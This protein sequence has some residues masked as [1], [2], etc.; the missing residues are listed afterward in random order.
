MKVEVSIH[1]MRAA[2]RSVPAMQSA[3]AAVLVPGS[4]ELVLPTDNSMLQF[5]DAARDIHMDKLQV[6]CQRSFY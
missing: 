5:W 2:P 4:S 6:R 1:G 3:A